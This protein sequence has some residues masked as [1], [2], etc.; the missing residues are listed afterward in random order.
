MLSIERIFS[1]RGNREDIL[2]R[3]LSTSDWPLRIDCFCDLREA[4]REP[5]SV[6]STEN[7]HRDVCVE[8]YYSGFR[9][10]MHCGGG[11]RLFVG[12]MLWSGSEARI[13]R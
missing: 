5:A 2:C 11:F 13:W 6:H 9:K 10:M 8:I 12:G 4:N 7:Q 1:K 3:D